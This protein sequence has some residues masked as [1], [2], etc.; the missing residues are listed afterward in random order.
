[1]LTDDNLQ[2]VAEA[3]RHG[4]KIFLNLKKAVRY[5]LSIHIPIILT[6]SLPLLLG[7][8]YPNIFTP[9]HVIFLELIMGPTCS[10]FYE[11]EPEE[12]DSM[13]R[14]PR[15]KNT[16]LFQQEEL[17]MGVV[18][19]L[20]ITAGVLGLYHYFMQQG[21]TLA[22]TRTVV[23]TTLIISNIFLTF[24]NRSSTEP[25]FITLRYKNPLAPVVFIASLFFLLVIHFVPVFREIFGM[26]SIRSGDFLL[27][28][29]TAFVSVAWFEII[30]TGRYRRTALERKTK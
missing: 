10:I 24:V 25:I 21:S 6:A 17:L 29:I 16:G 5:I 7:W 4:R 13:Q 19:G 28:T 20:L 2:H 14:P 22:Y 27:C 30:K 18:Q 11:N 1:M 23:F 15:R 9:V 12:P 26:V 3:I 8:T